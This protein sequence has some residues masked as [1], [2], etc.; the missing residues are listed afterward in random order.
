MFFSF[1]TTDTTASVW[2]V[3]TGNILMKYVGHSG[4]VNSIAFHPTEHYA[5]T[6]SGDTTAHVWRCKM[7]PSSLQRQWSCSN[8]AAEKTVS[9]FSCYNMYTQKSY[10]LQCRKCEERCSSDRVIKCTEV[11]KDLATVLPPPFLTFNKTLSPPP[12]Q[13]KQDSS[14][15]D[16]N[17]SDEDQTDTVEM[18]VVKTPFMILR[19]HKGK[20]I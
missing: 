8:S 14:G 2:D 6:T 4:S 17:L 1:Q 10:Q 7:N 15:E 12:Q 11:L 3:D 20:G 19:A 13:S 16:K 5:C 18:S 9:S